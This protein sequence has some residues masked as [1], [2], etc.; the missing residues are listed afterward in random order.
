MKKKKSSNSSSSRSGWLKLTLELIAVFVGITAGFFLNNFREDYADKQQ[1]GKYLESFLTNVK[2]DSA[3]IS[4]HIKAN[5]NNVDISGR[6]VATMQAENMTWDSALA[7]IQVM[8]SYNNLN[9]ED[10][11]YK[12]IVNS[13]NLGLIRDFE[14]REQLVN[15]YSFHEDIAYVEKVYNDYITTYVVPFVFE[16]IDM[17]TGEMPVHFRLDSREFRN[18]TSGYYVIASQKMELVLELDSVNNALKNALAAPK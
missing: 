12:S 4:N 11:T 7:V 6:T 5:Q 3:E 10:A 15:Y 17:I 9:L 16:N 8:A 18:V 1:E 13:G 14:I 2:S